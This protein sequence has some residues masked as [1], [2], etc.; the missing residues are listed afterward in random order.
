MVIIHIQI[1]K[2]L[3]VKYVYKMKIVD[4]GVQ[5]LKIYIQIHF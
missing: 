2:Y 1:N 4:I 3:M 5:V